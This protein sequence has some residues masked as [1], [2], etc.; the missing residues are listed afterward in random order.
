MSLFC[1]SHLWYENQELYLDGMSE[2]RPKL[3]VYVWKIIYRAVIRGCWT[4]RLIIGYKSLT[5]LCTCLWSIKDAH[6]SSTCMFHVITNLQTSMGFT[7][8]SNCVPARSGMT[9]FVPLDQ[10]EHASTFKNVRVI[11]LPILSPKVNVNVSRSR[12]SS[13]SSHACRKWIWFCAQWE[14]IKKYQQ[15]NLDRKSDF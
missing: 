11:Y 9:R 2:L 5:T 8:T 6:V 15:Y 12:P 4:T 7:A 3:Y 13:G 10:A 14:V 1:S